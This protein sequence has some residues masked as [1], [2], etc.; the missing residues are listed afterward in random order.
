[1]PNVT[2]NHGDAALVFSKDMSEVRVIIEKKDTLEEAELLA[3]GVSM[4]LDNASWRRK[5]CLRTKE[6]LENESRGNP[7]DSGR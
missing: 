1:M 4:M 6:V 3:I 7:E 5:I 2:L